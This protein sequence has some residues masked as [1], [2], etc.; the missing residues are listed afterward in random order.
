[1]KALV[2]GA[3]GFVGGHLIARLRSLRWD[4]S[5]TRLAREHINAPGSVYE[6]DILDQAATAGLLEQLRPD[7]VFHL[8]AQSSVAL[9]WEQPALTVD[10]NVKGTVHLLEAL[11]HIT[12]P[13]R[14]LLIGSGEEYGYVLPEEL[15]VREDTPLRP[16]S[17]YAGTKAA[18]S[19]LGQIYARAYGL[20]IITARAFNHIGPGQL[21][22]FAVANFC[23]QVAEIEAGLHPPVI[24]AGNLSARR[25]FTDVRDIVKAYSLLIQKGRPGEV[26]NV[27][28]G[29]A[30]PLREVLDLILSLS[31]VKI[32]V[33]QD[34][35]RLRPADTPVIEADTARLAS[36]TGWAPEISLR[37]S[38]A[39]SLE[40]WRKRIRG[41]P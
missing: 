10:V 34:A 1:V 7:Y 9:S 25:D 13:P 30:V 5:A 12:P 36:L 17:I 40:Y 23:R 8:A 31:P 29:R 33:A 2:T 22:T 27:G 26:Y 39:D 4:V 19:L 35:A 41:Q 28:S 20:E 18:Q 15:P 6:L 3:A 32:S 16:G 38:L 37:D 21:D 14:V 24:Q 11:R